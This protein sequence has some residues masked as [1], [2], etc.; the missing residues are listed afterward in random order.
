MTYISLE[1]EYAKETGVTPQDIAKLRQWLKTQP[2]LPEKHITDLDLILAF[3]ACNCSTGLAK[4]VLDLNLTLRTLFHNF[5]KDRSVD[6]A[7]KVATDILFTSVTPLSSKGDKIFYSRIL[8]TDPKIFHFGEAVKTVLMVLE[9]LQYEEGTWPGLQFV[10]DYEGVTLAHFAKID[11]FTLQH[12]LYY[13][14]EGILLKLNGLQFINAP[15]FIDKLLMLMKPFMTK[16]LMDKLHVHTANSKTLENFFSVEDLPK[17]ENFEAHRDK[18]LKRLQEFRQYFEEEKHKRVTESLRP[19]KP[20][21][22]S[23]IFGGVEGSFKTLDI[24]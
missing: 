15:S 14:Q 20:K 22:I 24:D 23:D 8:N 10:I 3:H 18:T 17:A 9:T 5:Y 1:Q 13:L 19:G 11:I 6:R 2:H 16:E 12:F 4:Q 21:T 7:S